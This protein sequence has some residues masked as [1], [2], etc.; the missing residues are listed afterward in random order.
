MI[1]ANL[2][3]LHSRVFANSVYKLI[4]NKAICKYIFFSVFFVCKD[5][6]Q[7]LLYNY[8]ARD[9]FRNTL[10]PKDIIRLK[11]NKK[12]HERVFPSFFLH[13]LQKCYTKQPL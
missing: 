13:K 5:D 1:A 2:Q 3:R 12:M 10:K 6:L 9:E 8:T 7:M 11:L 4:K